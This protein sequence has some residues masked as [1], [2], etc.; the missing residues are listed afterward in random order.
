MSLTLEQTAK[1]VTVVAVIICFI[2]WHLS[3]FR[4]ITTKDEHKERCRK[5]FEELKRRIRKA[6][7]SECIFLEEQIDDFF[8]EYI[9]LVEFK[10]V[11]RKTSEL[12]AHLLKRQMELQHAVVH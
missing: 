11:S 5:S 12:H 8:Q 10:T 9:S 3:H 6:R 4:S 1:L 7:I 2:I